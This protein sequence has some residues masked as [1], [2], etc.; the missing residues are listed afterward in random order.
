MV[1]S[2]VDG[3]WVLERSQVEQAI[4]ERDD[5]RTN[6][7]ATAATGNGRRLRLSLGVN[8]VAALQRN[9]RLGR[10]WRGSWEVG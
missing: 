9:E 1:Y 10:S 3:A 2:L 5:V 6:C 7:K 8:V 4:E